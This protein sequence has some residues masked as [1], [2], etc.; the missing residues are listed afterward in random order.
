MKINIIFTLACVQLAT[1]VHKPHQ[2]VTLIP[3]K[4]FL[5][6]FHDA[7]RSNR[8]SKTNTIKICITEG[9]MGLKTLHWTRNNIKY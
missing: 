5:V 1:A 9:E 7:I 4:I 6:L 2:P 8:A 3:H